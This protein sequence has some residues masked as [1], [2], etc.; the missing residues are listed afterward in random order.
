MKQEERRKAFLRR[1][2]SLRTIKGIKGIEGS[3]ILLGRLRTGQ[4]TWFELD[5]YNTAAQRKTIIRTYQR[6]LEAW[7]SKQPKA[8]TCQKPADGV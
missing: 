4:N 8:E 3:I 6:W 1:V 2:A 7:R 5:N